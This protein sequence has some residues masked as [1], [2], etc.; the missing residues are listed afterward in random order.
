M[1][2]EF[3]ISSYG[4]KWFK[5]GYSFYGN[6]GYFTITVYEGSIRIFNYRYYVSNFEFW[7]KTFRMKISKLTRD[8][9]SIKATNSSIVMC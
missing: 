8:L 5:N 1:I 6:N 7:M 9:F 4:L 2:T 3:E